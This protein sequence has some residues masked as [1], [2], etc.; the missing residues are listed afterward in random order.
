MI[1]DV[2]ALDTAVFTR[3]DAWRRYLLGQK[4][5]QHSSAPLRALFM[6]FF[7]LLRAFLI[8]ASRFFV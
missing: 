3:D 4:P 6:V 7:L 1:Y 8:S 2:N 5:P